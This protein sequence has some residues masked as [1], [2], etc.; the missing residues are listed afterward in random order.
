MNRVTCTVCHYDDCCDACYRNHYHRYGCHNRDC[1]L[2]QGDVVYEASSGMLYPLRRRDNA[3]RAADRDRDRERREEEEPYYYSQPSPSSSP[4]RYRGRNDDSGRGYAER[5]HRSRSQHRA[6]RESR[7]SPAEQPAEDPEL[8][9]LRT[10][11]ARATFDNNGNNG[12][13]SG[14]Y[15]SYSAYPPQP[16]SQSPPPPPPAPPAEWTPMLHQPWETFHDELE[17]RPW[18]P[19]PP[20]AAEYY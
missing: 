11:F 6:R 10:R 16:Q 3:G 9:R 18:A 15:Y 5:R 19:S 7:S 17:G 20:P 13:G 12:G 1:P 2:Y 14:G 8:E 4:R